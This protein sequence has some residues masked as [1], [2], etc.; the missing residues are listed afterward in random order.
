MSDLIERLRKEAGK[1]AS[2]D[3]ISREGA[4]LAEAAAEIAKLKAE[5]A[6]AMEWNEKY[7]GDLEVLN[8]WHSE[9][10]AEAADLRRALGEPVA[11]RWRGPKGGWIYDENKPKWPCEPVFARAAISTE[12][13]EG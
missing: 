11:W 13:G 9:A 2:F 4:L 1:H 3:D 10:E 6:E 7:K 5:L 8:K 12:G